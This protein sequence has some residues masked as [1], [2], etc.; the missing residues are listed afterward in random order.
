MSPAKKIPPPKRGRPVNIWLRES[1]EVQVRG[2]RAFLAAE[3]IRPSDSGIIRAAL[4]MAKADKKFAA[5][6][7]DEEQADGR[8]KTKK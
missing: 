4:S 1:D 7:Q 5:A 6:Y 3:G 8:L 2:L